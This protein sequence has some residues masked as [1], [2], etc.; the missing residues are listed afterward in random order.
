MLFGSLKF[1]VCVVFAMKSSLKID[2]IQVAENCFRESADL[3][4]LLI[5]TIPFVQWWV[6]NTKAV[7]KHFAARKILVTPFF[8]V[9]TAP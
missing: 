3:V 4:M 5:L 6:F 9:I 7:L 1:F 8:S 2:F